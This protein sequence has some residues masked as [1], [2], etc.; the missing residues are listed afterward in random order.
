M[1]IKTVAATGLK[2]PHFK[3]DLDAVTVFVGKSEAG[4]SCVM[5]AIAVALLGRHPTLKGHGNQGTFK[6][7][8]GS[9]MTCGVQLDDGRELMRSFTSDG[10]KIE[11]L[12]SPDCENFQMPEMLFNLGK[13]FAMT[14]AERLNLIFS[15]CAI[16]ANEGHEKILASLRSM[17]L[18]T[19]TEYHEEAIKAV[20]DEATVAWDQAQAE[21]A[22][23]QDWIAL[24]LK[25]LG[26]QLKAARASIKDFGGL[27]T[28]EAQLRAA[29]G[30]GL[31]ENVETELAAHREALAAL[32]LELQRAEDGRQV[33]ATAEAKL[34]AVRGM[35]ERALP[36][37]S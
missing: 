16:D 27:V 35:L 18:E 4:K 26:E 3:H 15:L 21:Q 10:E 1:R 20:V 6:L 9:K 22:S 17:L 31:V 23:L 14:E 29:R 7:A 5:D 11:A 24:L 34:A 30:A 32:E 12:D 13:Y 36:K 33:R 19:S 8:R 37:V 28:A 25:E 2:L